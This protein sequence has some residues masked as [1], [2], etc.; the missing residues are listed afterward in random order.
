MSDDVSSRGHWQGFS[1]ARS[2]MR[3]TVGSW[4]ATL[5]V[6]CNRVAKYCTGLL[7]ALLIGHV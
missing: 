3:R 5:D 2:R 7:D 1:V 6:R 4:D